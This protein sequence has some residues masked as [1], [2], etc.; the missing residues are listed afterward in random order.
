MAKKNR[1]LLINEQSMSF[2]FVEMK[3]DE[4]TGH[5]F[6]NEKDSLGKPMSVEFY[7]GDA[8]EDS[9]AGYGYT[10][11]ANIDMNGNVSNGNENLTFKIIDFDSI[12]HLNGKD[13][14]IADMFDFNGKT[15]DFISAYIQL[16]TDGKIED[17]TQLQSFLE[18]RCVKE[19]VNEK[20]EP[21][22]TKDAEAL[23]SLHATFGELDKAIASFD[24]VGYKGV[25]EEKALDIIYKVLY[26][27]ASENGDKNRGIAGQLAIANELLANDKSNYSEAKKQV[28]LN[29]E[30]GDEVSKY[31]A[32]EQRADVE[33]KVA[34]NLVDY[35][36]SIAPATMVKKIAGVANG[37]ATMGI[38]AIAIGLAVGTT[39]LT[40]MAGAVAIGV[41][42]VLGAV[43]A[44][45]FITSLFWHPEK[46]KI[47][48]AVMAEKKSEYNT[49]ER[50]LKTLSKNNNVNDIVKQI[51][52]LD[53]SIVKA[54]KNPEMVNPTNDASKETKTKFKDAVD[55][56]KGNIEER[57]C[58]MMGV[59]PDESGKYN[60][61]AI[62]T[63]RGRLDAFSGNKHVA[64][65]QK[66]YDKLD[67]DY[68]D[69]FGEKEADEV[70][71]LE[72]TPEGDTDASTTDNDDDATEEVVE[73]P[74]PT[75]EEAHTEADEA[76]GSTETADESAESKGKGDT[77]ET[78]VEPTPVVKDE[79]KPEIKD[80][81]DV[82]EAKEKDFVQREK[83]HPVTP[84]DLVRMSETGNKAPN[85]NW[86]KNAESQKVGKLGSTEA[87]TINGFLHALSEC[88]GYEK[89]DPTCSSS[90]KTQSGTFVNTVEITGNDGGKNFEVIGRL[91][92][93]SAFI[94]SNGDTIETNGCP[95]SNDKFFEKG[96]VDA[97]THFTTQN[98]V[99]PDS[100]IDAY[101]GLRALDVEINNAIDNHQGAEKI[102]HEPL[103][104][105]HDGIAEF[106]PDTI[107]TIKK[108]SKEDQGDIADLINQLKDSEA[109]PEE[110]KDELD[111]MLD[112]IG[113]EKQG[114]DIEQ[115]VESGDESN[116]HNFTNQADEP[117]EIQTGEIGDEN[118]VGDD[119]LD[120]SEEM[121]EDHDDDYDYDR[122]D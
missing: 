33:Q 113:A 25:K 110:L 65:I 86:A 115:Q 85:D 122:E 3:H 44:I 105:E 100:V 72:T 60:A 69:L 106:N 109:F 98:Q 118:K 11:R 42:A 12:Q 111:K 83:S 18:S 36:Y 70:E 81:R 78:P 1:V 54:S 4:E 88:R 67:K 41:G 61:E 101:M 80:S 39:F 66:A 5:Y 90:A 45:S 108:L 97:L 75:E 23:N 82:A 51:N 10:Y 96:S 17:R 63:M 99:S 8:T 19:N 40:P 57:L 38:G 62:Q 50:Q 104:V 46:G 52:D 117:T 2:N 93:E 47:K 71:V 20:G 120:E 59:K 13:V 91:T 92:N 112:E 77:T 28:Q 15:E 32:Q 107:K 31:F 27:G 114:K 68:T 94:L 56:V 30:T 24:N 73:E 116:I 9:L 87:S 119:G 16:A 95:K 58:K 89:L 49:L 14:R 48:K 53:K 37:V 103:I 22:Q 64:E 6:L 35:R 7:K 76:K 26:N 34:D 21:V 121:H 55:D 84:A 43:G 29:Y 74:K 102:A 79:P